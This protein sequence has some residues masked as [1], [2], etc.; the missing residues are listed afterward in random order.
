MSWQ[1]KR[2]RKQSTNLHHIP[3]R[4]PAKA[5]PFKIRIS[6]RDHAAYHQLFQNA[7]SFEQCVAIL[8]RN[9]WKPYYEATGEHYDTCTDFAL[10]EAYQAST[11]PAKS[12]VA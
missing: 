4:H 8:Y 12:L 7:A 9:W 10:P 6:K 3:P 2:F 1:A 11:S 5:T